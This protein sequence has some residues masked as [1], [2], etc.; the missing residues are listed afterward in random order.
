MEI[1]KIL[2]NTY[3]KS[4]I[5]LFDEFLNECQKSYGKP[6]HNMLDLKKRTNTKIKG[7][8]FENFCVLYLKNIKNYENVWL[9][10]DVPENILEKLK[11]KRKDMGIDIIV[12]NN[13]MY[14]AVQCKYKK[15]N[16]FKKNI[17]SWKV[18]STFYA[19]CLKTGPF[20]KY[21]VMTNC[22]YVTHAVTKN[23]KDVS[24]CLKT[25]QNI[26][27]DEW[28][29]MC[30]IESNII[31]KNIENSDIDKEELRKKRLAFY[32]NL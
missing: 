17:L 8:T 27:K 30:N 7:D 24:I 14:Y 20:E 4:P 12:E 21:I 29:K 25:F 9:L 2:Y 18:L 15:N 26:S 32:N 10:K 13:N 3:L 22:E 1:D 31:N 23:E 5:N 19:L 6:V 28:L 16:T 11:L